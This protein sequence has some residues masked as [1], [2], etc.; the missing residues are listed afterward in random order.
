[1]PT[2]RRADAERNA[3]T[4]VAAT[5]DLL[6][7]GKLPTMSEVAAA[8]GVGRVTLYAHFPTRE[9]LIEAVVL[10]GVAETD[11]VLTALELDAVGVEEALERLVRTSW[12]I[13]DRHRKV[14]V[15]ALRAMGPDT[16]RSR[17]DAAFR[18]V[19]RLIARGQGE[20]TFRTDLSLEWLVATFYA[21]L[22]AAADEVEAG[23]M[24]ADGVPDTLIATLRSVLHA[25]RG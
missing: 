7:G 22:H 6:A 18:H 24:K 19:E 8:A 1:M 20:G 5:R 17:H 3:A 25:G 14:R 12:P 11:Q 15:A 23:R 21:V 10:R 13:L 4:I 9:D 2:K 16:L